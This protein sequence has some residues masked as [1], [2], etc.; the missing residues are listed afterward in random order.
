VACSTLSDDRVRDIQAWAHFEEVEALYEE[1]AEEVPAT[2][3]IP[4]LV[5]DEASPP[6]QGCLHLR[7]DRA[8]TCK[9]CGASLYRRDPPDTERR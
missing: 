9:D 2:E 4:P 1:R 8:M 7:V 6:P 3:G 5:P